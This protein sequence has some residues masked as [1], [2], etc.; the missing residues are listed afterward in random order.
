MTTMTIHPPRR[1]QDFPWMDVHPEPLSKE[2][3]KISLPSIRQAF[4][5]FEQQLQRNVVLATPYS[6]TSPAKGS[7]SKERTPPEYIHSPAYHKRHFESREDVERTNSVPRRL[8]SSNESPYRSVSPPVDSRADIEAWKKPIRASYPTYDSAHLQYPPKPGYYD[9]AEDQAT[10]SKFST[11]NLVRDRID[12]SPGLSSD[13]YIRETHRRT[14]SPEDT[15]ISTYGLEIR[16]ASYRPTGYHYGY[17]HP[18]RV[19]SLSVG[20]AHLMNRPSIYSPVLSPATYGHQPR[21][22]YMPVR[23]VGVGGNYEGKQRKRRGNLPKETTDKLRAWFHSHLS[24]PYPTEEEK[25]QLMKQ[26]GLQLNQ[27]SN[28]FINARRRQLPSMINNA[29]AEADAMTVRGAE[30]GLLPSTERGDYDAD[31]RPLSDEEAGEAGDVET[32]STK[33]RRVTCNKRGSI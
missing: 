2:V 22:R 18:N 33:R 13:D 26:T 30:N 28:W 21:D 32:E 31:G 27:I 23:E 9:Q 3:G 1:P 20:S 15:G 5:D 6:S 12:P 19:Q 17:H 16:P 7:S 24:H 4:P 29:R 11:L 14:R 10:I 25:Q 8:T